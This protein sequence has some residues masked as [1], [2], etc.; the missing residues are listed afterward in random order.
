MIYDMTCD[1]CHIIVL[2]VEMVHSNTPLG[3]SL[4]CDKPPSRNAASNARSCWHARP[5]GF[6]KH[7]NRRAVATDSRPSCWSGNW[8]PNQRTCLA[9][10]SLNQ[11]L[12]EDVGHIVRRRHFLHPIS[13]L[14]VAAWTQRY[15]TFTCL[16]L[17]PRPL[18]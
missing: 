16:V 9:K 18:R 12:G 1:I 13:S 15:W 5:T 4:L 17:P 7:L 3:L 8:Y 10:N 11:K 6:A 14:W 2:P